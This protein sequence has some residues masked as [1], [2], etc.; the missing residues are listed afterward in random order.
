MGVVRD[1]APR[2]YVFE[3]EDGEGYELPGNEADD[4]HFRAAESKLEELKT[5]RGDKA[6]SSERL[7]VLSNVLDG[8]IDEQQLQQ[9]IKI[10]WN[11]SNKKRLKAPQ[12]EALISWAKEDDYFVNEVESLLTLVDDEEE[13]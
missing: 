4:S 6:V 1:L 2:S 9:L 13:E 7:T 11:Q 5:I 8:Q 12:V 3:E 10:V